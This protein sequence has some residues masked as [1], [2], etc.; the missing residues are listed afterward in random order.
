MS[1]SL[2][3]TVRFHDGRYHGEDD[4][5]NGTEGW[6][7]SPARL[8]QALVA[9]AAQGRLIDPEDQRALRWL[10]RLPAPQI[11][12]PPARRGA[13][14]PHFVP[15]ND[16]DAKGGDP[17]RVAEIRIGK[18]WRPCFFNVS[19]PVVYVWYLESQLPDEA[20]RICAMANRLYQLGRGIDMAAA[21]GTVASAERAHAL[22]AA[23]PGTT[24]TPA[25]AGN[26]PVAIP[27]TFA[28][29]MERRQRRRERLTRSYDGKLLFTQPPKAVFRHIG[30]DAPAKRLHFEVRKQGAFAPYPLRS[31]ATFTVGLRDAV[32]ERLQHGLQGRVAEIERLVVGRGAGPRDIGQR[33][34]ITPVPS[35]GM[36]HTDRSIRRVMV[37]V[38]P[39]CPLS[40]RDIGWAFADAQPC[41]NHAGRLLS[42]TDATMAE[43]YLRPARTFRSVTA[44]ALTRARRH[45][46]KR[47]V[48]GKGAPQRNDEEALARAAL[49]Q[50]LRHLGVS[51]VPAY[52]HVQREPLHR[53]GAPAES[54]AAGTR[55][56]PR[57]MWHAEIR[58]R[59]PI[60]G[61]LVVGDGRF[62][63]LGLFEPVVDYDDVL[64][65]YIPAQTVRDDQ[66]AEIVHALRR[67]LMSRA[68]DDDG[69]VPRLFSGHENDGRPDGLSG[70]HN[71]VFIAADARGGWISRLVVQAPW[72]VDR[73]LRA[74]PGQQR[75]FTDTVSGL[76]ILRAGRLG[77]FPMQA[78][79]LRD[80]DSLIGPARHW[81]SA[82]PYLATRNMKKKDDLEAAVCVDVRSQCHRLGLPAP[83]RIKVLSASVGP[84]GGRPTATL[85]L[86]FA[87]AVRGPLLLGRDSHRGGGM[88]RS[89]DERLIAAELVPQAGAIDL[90]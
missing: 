29:L 59:L 12:A 17:G 34:R 1:Q 15:N 42:T 4:G 75:I 90:D 5:F 68:R 19:H 83:E 30:Y 89:C 76:D 39:E 84:R 65:F 10:E 43:R 2:V 44:L 74:R 9:G 71:H 72:A 31:A 13:A 45:N 63:G 33:I 78:V 6:P 18:S 49:V 11:A 67:A 51:D 61:P 53:R 77:V 50:A 81:R 28:S 7:P 25:G 37:E 38:P 64:G 85:S 87:T 22:L 21:T 69:G 26:V 54:F 46:P 60:A 47:G 88:F 56:S 80:G 82:R 58:F 3:I 16:L 23:H 52:I 86:H 35:I 73:S 32:A 62:C 24:R 70:H 36:E 66:F 20:K 57:A 48:A 41:L 27:G 55:F 8:F 40:S 79:T 14:V